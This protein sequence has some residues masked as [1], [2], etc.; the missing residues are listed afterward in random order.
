MGV[1]KKGG[2]LLCGLVLG[3]EEEIDRSHSM[4]VPRQIM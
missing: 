4:A 3:E 2:F 1:P